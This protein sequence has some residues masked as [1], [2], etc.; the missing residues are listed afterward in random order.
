MSNFVSGTRPLSERERNLPTLE[1]TLE[2]FQ[3][4]VDRKVARKRRRQGFR[5]SYIS[6]STPATRAAMLRMQGERDEDA[7]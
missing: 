4:A 2:G 7:A 1:G 6:R 3:Q 5:Q